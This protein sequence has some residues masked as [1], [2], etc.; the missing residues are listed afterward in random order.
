MALPLGDLWCRLRHNRRWGGGTRLGEPGFHNAPTRPGSSSATTASVLTNAPTRPSSRCCAHQRAAV[1][2]SCAPL[3]PDT[4][5][6]TA[7]SRGREGR[8]ARVRLPRCRLLRAL[9]SRR[10]LC[11]VLGGDDAGHPLPN[12][13]RRFPQQRWRGGRGGGG[14]DGGLDV[15]LAVVHEVELLA[16]DAAGAHDERVQRHIPAR[17]KETA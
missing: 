8:A 10:R 16:V 5:S 2:G 12:G 6:G 15:A 17:S 11:H 1:L 14:D 13:A 4:G 3:D 9:R 7:M